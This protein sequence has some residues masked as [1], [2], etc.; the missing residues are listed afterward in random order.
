MRKTVRTLLI[1]IKRLGRSISLCCLRESVIIF[2]CSLIQGVGSRRQI[3][4]WVNL[5]RTALSGTPE[6]RSL[7][8]TPLPPPH[9]HGDNYCWST[10]VNQ[11]SKIMAIVNGLRISADYIW[12]SELYPVSPAFR[13]SLNLSFTFFFHHSFMNLCLLLSASHQFSPSSRKLSKNKNLLVFKVSWG[14]SFQIYFWPMS[15]GCCKDYW[16]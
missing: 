8:Q 11:L 9:Y 5:L 12:F 13:G 2:H 4:F 7:I 3:Y 14:S 6:L 10:S 15:Q 1:Q 16:G